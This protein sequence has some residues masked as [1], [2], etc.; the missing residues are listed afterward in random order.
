MLEYS[1]IPNLFRDLTFISLKILKSRRTNYRQQ[2]RKTE[3]ITFLD[4]LI[5]FT[6]YA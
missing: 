4:N 6:S 1:V 2:L 5:Y 3:L